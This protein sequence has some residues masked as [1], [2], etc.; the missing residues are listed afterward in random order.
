MLDLCSY[1]SMVDYLLVW[2]TPD[3]FFKDDIDRCYNLI[4]TKG[5]Q[6]IY[7]PRR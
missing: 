3:Y 7:V 1:T 6:K 2:D 4:Y 5:R